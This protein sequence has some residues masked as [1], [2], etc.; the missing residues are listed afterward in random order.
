M[1][2][3]VKVVYRVSCPNHQVD[4]PSYWDYLDSPEVA[5]AWI[6]LHNLQHHGG[7]AEG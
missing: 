6:T 3:R 5:Q 2:G 4:E 7:R 1:N